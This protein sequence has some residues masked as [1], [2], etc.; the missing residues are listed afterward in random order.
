[1]LLFVCETVM[2]AFG[3]QHQPNEAEKYMTDDVCES[4][5]K[6]TNNSASGRKRKENCKNK[7]LPPTR[8]ELPTYLHKHAYPEIVV[9]KAYLGEL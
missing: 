5:K 3:L 8:K 2:S 7:L 4:C 9:L 6:S 1:M